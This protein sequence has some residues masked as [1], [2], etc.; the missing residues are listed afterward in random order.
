MNEPESRGCT[1]TIT[2]RLGSRRQLFV[3]SILYLPLI[4]IAMVCGTL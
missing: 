3:G 1:A 4:W 2:A